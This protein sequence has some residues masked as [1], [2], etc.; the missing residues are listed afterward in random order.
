[1]AVT[2]AATMITKPST[3]RTDVTGDPDDEQGQTDEEAD[4]GHSG[5]TAV[6]S[7]DSGAAQR[8]DQLGV[9]SRKR[10]LHL[11]EKPLLLIREGHWPHPLGS[12]RAL[13]S[14]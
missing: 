6:H 7:T 13:P 12:R 3:L 1:M 2:A 8:V 4:A 9:L 5:P 10:S 14:S 11:L